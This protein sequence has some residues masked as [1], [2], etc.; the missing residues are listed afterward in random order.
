[1]L[2]TRFLAKYYF[3]ILYH[4]KDLRTTSVHQLCTEVYFPFEMLASPS[5]LM[6]VGEKPKMTLVY[7]LF[8]MSQVYTISFI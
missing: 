4:I 8:A 7:N 2:A 5:Y 1:M 3:Y 6:F